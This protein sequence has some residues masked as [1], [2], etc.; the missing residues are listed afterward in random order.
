MVSCV[1]GQRCGL[2]L[3]LLWLWCRL[4]ARAP[5]P[6]L[7]WE[8]PYATSAALKSKNKQ[9]TNKQTKNSISER[10]EIKFGFSNVGLSISYSILFLRTGKIGLL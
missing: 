9:T 1:V 6:S 7:A 2:D 5:I 10:A 3:M 4:A 8:P